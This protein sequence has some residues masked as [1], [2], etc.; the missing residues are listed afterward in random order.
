V[1][2]FAFRLYAPRPEV[3]AHPRHCSSLPDPTIVP[4]AGRL[5]AGARALQPLPCDLA[6]APP[7]R[8]GG[9]QRAL[10]AGVDRLRDGCVWVACRLEQ[11]LACESADS[12][13]VGTHLGS[14]WVLRRLD[15]FSL[16]LRM[17]LSYWGSFR[18]RERHEVDMVG[19]RDRLDPGDQLGLCGSKD[20]GPDG[21]SGSALYKVRRSLVISA[22]SWPAP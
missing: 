22:A 17:L 19:G 5:L 9:G 11:K 18:L 6:R 3:P 2:L 15:G 14:R 13:A 1:A 4:S 21:M 20:L 10:D 12:L 8:L 16:R 7:D